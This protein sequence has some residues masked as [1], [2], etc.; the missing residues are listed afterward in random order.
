MPELALPDPP[1]ADD[2]VALRA[3]TLDDVGWVTEACRDPEIPRFTTVPDPYGDADARE[4]VGSHEEQRRAGEALTLAIVER[5]GGAPLGSAAVQDIAWDHLRGEI[6]YWVAPWARGRGAAARA[7]RLLAAHGFGTLGLKRIQIT[8]YVGNVASQRVAE[9][10]GCV[11]E[12][13]L[14][15]YF[16]A[17]GKRHDCLMYS[18]MPGDV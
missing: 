14:R 7:T 18:L 3:F 12:G 13:V 16:L 1:L 5:D 11:R 10:A 17:H 15:S 9:S 6:G 4:W 8:V 2:L